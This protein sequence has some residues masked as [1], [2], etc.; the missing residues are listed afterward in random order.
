MKTILIMIALFVSFFCAQAHAVDCDG[1]VVLD[2]DV[3]YHQGVIKVSEGTSVLYLIRANKNAAQK[4]ME[5]LKGQ[6]GDFQKY[7]DWAWGNDKALVEAFRDHTRAY[8]YV[9]GGDDFRKKVEMCKIE[10]VEFD[11]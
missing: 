5:A 3:A 2:R 10:E 9:L 11:L 7:T 6:V 4:L 8:V 1:I